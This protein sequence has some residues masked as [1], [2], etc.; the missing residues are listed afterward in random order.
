[1]VLLDDVQFPRGRGWMNR[2]RLKGD[3]GELWLTV[4][5]QRKGRGLQTIRNVEI[6]NKSQWRNKHQHGLRHNYVHAPY[7]EYYFPSII[8]VYEKD[9][10]KLISLNLDFIRFFWDALSLKS[11]LLLQSD[12]G[13][14]GKGT[15]LLICICKHMKAKDYLAFSAAKKYLDLEK[16]KKNGFQVNFVNFHPPVYPQLWGNFIPNLSVL[17][18]LLNCGPKSGEII[19][20]T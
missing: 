13:I 16:M 2:N 17:D 8:N 10:Q 3:K 5:V 7:F 15:D 20:K 18:L 1:M 4:P 19:S 14:T 12:L 11:T 6:F 9:H